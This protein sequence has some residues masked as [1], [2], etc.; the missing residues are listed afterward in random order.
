MVLVKVPMPGGGRGAHRQEGEHVQEMSS[1]RE[2]NMQHLQLPKF[3]F[4]RKASTFTL[5]PASDL[6]SQGSSA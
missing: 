4:V 6:L 3:T 5:I 2:I 1:T